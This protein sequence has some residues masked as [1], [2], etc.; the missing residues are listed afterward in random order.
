MAKYE[1]SIKAS[2]LPGWGCFEGVRELIQNARDSEVQYNAPMTVKYSVRQRNGKKTGAIIIANDGVV[3]PKEALLIGHTTKGGDNRLIGK[4]GEG[5]KFGVLALL[6]LGVEIKIRNGPEVWTPSV[7]RSDKFNADVLVFNVTTGH[8]NENRIQFEVVGIDESDWSDISSKLLFINTY[9][10]SVK[11]PDGHVLTLPQHK[12]QVYVKGMFVAKTESFFGYD[13]DDADIDR[14]RRMVNN[15]S[16]KTSMLLAQAVNQGVLVPK[17]F[18][19]MREGADEVSYLSQ[20]RLDPKGKKSIAE[21]FQRENPGVIPVERIEQVQELESFGKRGQQVP[22]NLRGI[23]ESEIGTAG[24]QLVELR[25]S[26]RI[27]YSISELTQFERDNL[28]AVVSM[29]GRACQKLGDVVVS[30][31]NIFV[32]DFNKT[33]CLGTYDP[34][35]GNVRLSRAVLENKGK[36]LYTLVHEVAHTHG[37]DGVRSHE[38]AIGRLMECILN[39]IL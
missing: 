38:Y 33:D 7:E 27:Q 39:E 14:E 37:G 36:A 34:N 9:P 3:L 35:T 25:R 11:V 15:L 23:L 4:F 5:L 19:L 8:K 22:W 30:L 32:V 26:D 2:Y 1:L 21:M 13:F 29:V 12:G 16:D 20:W 6:R 31:D 24:Q 10:E 28:R 17:V 18:E